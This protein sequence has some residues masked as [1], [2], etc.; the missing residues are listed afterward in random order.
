MR[1]TAL[2]NQKKAKA[3][4]TAN[5][6]TNNLPM[7]PQELKQFYK[8]QAL[9]QLKQVTANT[10]EADKSENN[11]RFQEWLNLANL[12][13]QVELPDQAFAHATIALERYDDRNNYAG[14]KTPLLMA[15]SANS[16]A[17]L[18][19][20]TQGESLL[21]QALRKSEALFGFNSASYYAQLAQL[22]SFILTRKKQTSALALWTDFAMSAHEF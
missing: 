6:A 4:N 20:Y 9:G 11:N 18:G 1:R 12:E 7:S 5:T 8:A 2:E 15:A 14:F 17:S 22:A 10:M 19:H 13:L 3:G 21:K 16:L